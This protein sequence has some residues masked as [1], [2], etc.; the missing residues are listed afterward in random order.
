TARTDKKEHIAWSLEVITRQMQHLSRLI[1]DLMD[2]SRITRGMIE[3]R[4]KLVDATLI[5]ESAA[6]TVKSLV[7]ERKHTLEFDIERGGL[8]VD[9]DP[10]R[11]E[12]VVVNLLNNA[13]KYS[14]N[15]GYIK[16]SGRNEAGEVVISVK[17]RGV[18]I[19]AE[20]LPEMFELFAQGD[21]SLARS[22]GGLGIG[23]T[24]VKKLVEM[25]GGTVV[26]RSAG[27]GEGSEFVI[28]LPAA[29]RPTTTLTAATGPETKASR[30]P[31]ILV[32]DDSVDTA[33]GIALL[34]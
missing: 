21:R 4:R 26:A 34:L 23:L 17:D 1:D 16:L 27:P 7:D 18:G 25:H 24:V 28:R 19:P 12:Q 30:K 22:E 6:A 33:R 32:V 20:K 8:W 29:Q 13:A 31:R 10:T 3:L 11:L 14:D 5:L 15:G 9:A 2:V